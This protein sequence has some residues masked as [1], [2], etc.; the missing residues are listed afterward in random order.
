ML[1]VT[2]FIAAAI[3]IALLAGILWGY[4]GI[5]VSAVFGD[6]QAR[7]VVGAFGFLFALMGVTWA[8]TEWL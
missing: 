2:E 8:V 1:G 6:T 4:A 7:G 3:L 5:L